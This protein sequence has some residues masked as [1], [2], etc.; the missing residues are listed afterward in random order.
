M[1]FKEGSQQAALYREKQAVIYTGGNGP[2][3]I[4]EETSTLLFKE[5]SLSPVLYT[6]ESSSRHVYRKKAS[7]LP[8]IGRSEPC[9]VYRGE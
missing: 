4:Q 1:L 2:C 9:V 3:R 7:K 5:G 6:G 8:Y